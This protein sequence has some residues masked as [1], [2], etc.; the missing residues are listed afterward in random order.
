MRNRILHVTMLGLHL[1]MY[2]VMLT[3]WTDIVLNL[4]NLLLPTLVLHSLYSGTIPSF[5]QTI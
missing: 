3:N 5:S 1:P 2:L 4:L